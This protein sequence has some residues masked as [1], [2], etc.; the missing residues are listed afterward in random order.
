MGVIGTNVAFL[1]LGL[2]AAAAQEPS[3]TLT[4]SAA[5]EGRD[6]VV[7]VYWLHDVG[8]SPAAQ[9]H[10]ALRD[11]LTIDVP[12]RMVVVRL[13]PKDAA[14]VSFVLSPGTASTRLKLPPLT[15][16]GE[17]VGVLPRREFSPEGLDLASASAQRRIV[18]DG[19]GVFEAGGLPPGEYTLVPRYRGGVAGS[20]Q[21]VVVRNGE[22]SELLPLPLPESGA[23]TVDVAAD[24]C[25]RGPRLTLSRAAV[26][27]DA[28]PIVVQQLHGSQCRHEIEGLAQGTYDASLSEAG[29]G[30]MRLLAQARFDVANGRRAAVSL[31]PVVSVFGQARLAQGQPLAGVTV[32]FELS[33]RRWQTKTDESGEY[34][35]TLER[36]GDYRV[37]VGAAPS[38]P[39]I[40]LSRTL[41]VGSQRT[42]LELGNA[43]LYVRVALEDGGVP[44]EAVQVALNA[45]NGRRIEGSWQFDDS[46]VARF[47]GVPYDEYRVTATTPSGL[48][49]QSAVTVRVSAESPLG[50]IDLVL[51]SHAGTVRV[52]DAPGRPLA[53]ARG[54]TAAMPLKEVSAGVFSLAGVA[55]GEG[56]RVQAPGFVPKCH[57]LQDGDLPDLS[58]VLEP[59]T[60]HVTLHIEAGVNWESAT[61][62]GVTDADCPIG[63]DA[64]DLQANVARDE[65]TVVLGL[66]A[67]SFALVVD[68]RTFPIVIPGGD[69]QVR[70]PQ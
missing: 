35:L 32:E 64:F 50:E 10:V 7:E 17:I 66:A 4:L 24:A 34:A 57:T 59:A 33:G 53:G 14:P 1:L 44:G 45:S 48:S 43:A 47:V 8:T 15:T 41:S 63:I 56:L 18:P 49:S 67:G 52:V 28:R 25:V 11:T 22:T 51:G 61:I 30:G 36:P 23:V 46:A 12:T 21:K 9:Q 37:S 3:R 16:G 62:T 55:L 54:Q 26:D 42:D 60:D 2:A 58:L 27:A 65:A 20:P 70:L 31:V 19:R 40:E 69:V 13:R 39:A 6:T 5:W 38:V 68:G 29:E